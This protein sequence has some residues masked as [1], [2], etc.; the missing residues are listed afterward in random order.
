MEPAKEKNEQYKTDQFYD[1]QVVLSSFTVKNAFNTDVKSTSICTGYISKSLDG[2]YD[3]PSELLMSV[4]LNGKNLVFKNSNK[5]M[6]QIA[7]LCE[8]RKKY[9]EN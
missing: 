7:M 5:A 4:T 9:V 2:E 1:F 3:P 6:S 8:E